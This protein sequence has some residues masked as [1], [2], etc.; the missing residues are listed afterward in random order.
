MKTIKIRNVEFG[1][2]ASKIA[3][4]IVGETQEDIAKKGA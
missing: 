3:V 2:G 1:A 4:P